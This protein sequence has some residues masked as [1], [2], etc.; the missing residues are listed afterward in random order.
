[1]DEEIIIEKEYI[2]LAK[3]QMAKD[4]ALR[5]CHMCFHYETCKVK[6]G[7]KHYNYGAACFVT[8][9][10]ML[11]ALLLKE[12][13]RAWRCQEKLNEKMDV[14]NIMVSGADMIRQDIVD[15]IELE[16][17]RLDIKAKNDDAAY[18]RNK[19]KMDR[20]AKCYAQMKASMHTF[21]VA[22]RQYIEYWNAQVFADLD[23]NY[24]PEFDKHTHNV[25]FCTYM[26]FC[27]YEKMFMSEDNV[28]KL[29]ETLEAMQGK[30]IWDEGDL[31]RYL[32][33]I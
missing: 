3:A 28:R 10:Q 2:D 31:K 23:G 17:K 4:P 8:N 32:I 30:D 15:T 24:S 33:K 18:A 29:A 27:L 14:M 19:R 26:F 20:L 5:P 7:I 13:K 22:Y 9:E 25:G 16:F 1:M 21:E 6:K 11:R 12:R